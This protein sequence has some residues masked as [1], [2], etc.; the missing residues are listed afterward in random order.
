MVAQLFEIDVTELRE[1]LSNE[2]DMLLELWK[3]ILPS[4]LLMLHK[5]CLLELP[6]SLFELQWKDAWSILKQHTELK[7]FG[8]NE[9]V[10]LRNG[11]FLL[12]GSL[13]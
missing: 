4:A 1:I 3:V 10:D 7:I 6:K 9:T 8:I 11:G 13:E 12:Q 5:Q 2:K